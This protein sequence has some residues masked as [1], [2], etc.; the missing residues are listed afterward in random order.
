MRRIESREHFPD[1]LESED[2]VVTMAGGLL[3]EVVEVSEWQWRRF[4]QI[5]EHDA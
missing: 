3:Q 2:E 1:S 4:W 5:S